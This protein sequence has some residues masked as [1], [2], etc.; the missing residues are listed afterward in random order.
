A[1]RVAPDHRL[2]KTLAHLIAQ[3]A[4]RAL[5]VAAWEAQRV[6]V[7]TV[8]TQLLHIAPHRLRTTRGAMAEPD[9]RRI[10]VA[11]AD[12][13]QGDSQYRDVRGSPDARASEPYA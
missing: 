7:D 1:E 9:L 4:H 8:S 13:A 11:G 2:G 6:S 3:R 10:R 5:G 12:R